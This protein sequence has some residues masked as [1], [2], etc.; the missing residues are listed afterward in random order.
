M[1]ALSDL[2]VA[3]RQHFVFSILRVFGPEAT[4]GEVDDA[5]QHFKRALLTK[6]YGL[7]RN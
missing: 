3:H 5:E 6:Q 4:T 1:K 7:N 2:N